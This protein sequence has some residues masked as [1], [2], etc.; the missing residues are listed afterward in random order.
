MDQTPTKHYT[1]HQEPPKNHYHKKHKKSPQENTQHADLHIG[2]HVDL[3]HADLMPSRCS[4]R[5]QADL[6]RTILLWGNEEM[7]EK[8][9][10][11]MRK[12]ERE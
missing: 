10:E 2:L 7:R 6:K 8:G 9:N 5:H 3:L 4:P 1:N 12:T 11:E